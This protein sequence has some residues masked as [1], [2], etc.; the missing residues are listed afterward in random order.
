M[1]IDLRKL[2]HV[3]E[4][5][6]AES[7]T[8]AAHT[9]YIT[10]SALTR[11][12]AEVEAELGVALFQRLPRGV[13][14]TETGRVFVA[15][16]RTILGDMD[17]LLGSMADVTALN[18]G[19]LRLGAAPTV[20]QTFLGEAIGRLAREH[21]GISIEVITGPVN[22]LTPRLLGG[23]LDL[24]AGPHRTLEKWPE[25]QVEHIVDF[26][27]VMMM[28]LGHPLQQRATVTE[29]DV[30]HY[31]AVIPATLDPLL[32]DIAQIY[33]RHRL[34]RFQPQYAV[35]D[36]DLMRR[37]VNATDAFAPIISLEP[38]FGTLRDRFF[39]LED[40]VRMPVQ[41]MA[42][43]M[44]RNRTLSPA[45]RTFIETARQELGRHRHSTAE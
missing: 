6:R 20:Y 16:A 2:R 18:T 9:L 26:A 37:I 29:G 17:D 4:V 19:R 13:R 44:S 27:C 30:L 12:I 35:D 21:P 25:F 8:G 22:D 40:V 34:Q 10:Q 15:R 32:T 3:V 5:A 23:D 24:L 14:L 42:I 43:A 36:F 31:P 7:I 45:A 41:S 33:A 1:A 38:R 28:R 39:L 11:S